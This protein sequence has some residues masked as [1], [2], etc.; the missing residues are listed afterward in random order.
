MPCF[1]CLVV[2]LSK[3]R[4]HRPFFA[5]APGSGSVFHGRGK[6]KVYAYCTALLHC[7]LHPGAL[8]RCCT[9]ALFSAAVQ[10]VHYVRCTAPH[11]ST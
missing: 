1:F 3:A 10:T 9:A 4:A 11:N 2:G 7:R 8:A 5:P 6:Q